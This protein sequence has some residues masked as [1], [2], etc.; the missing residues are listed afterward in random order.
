ML[1]LINLINHINILYY[2]EQIP[3]KDIARKF[4]I[5]VDQVRNYRTKKEKYLCLSLDNAVKD[6]PFEYMEDLV[7]YIK[8]RLSEKLPL[9][10]SL[11][12][13]YIIDKYNIS[14]KN[15]FK[16]FQYRVQICQE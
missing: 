1:K 16:T 7:A 3:T 12:Y 14:I 6:K 5:S 15:A 13:S 4:N 10:R 9:Y 11:A 8:Q 2:E